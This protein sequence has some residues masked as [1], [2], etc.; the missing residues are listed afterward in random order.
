M[1]LKRRLEKLGWENIHT[2]NYSTFHGNVLQMVEE[3]GKRVEEIRKSTGAS[4]IDIIAHSLGGIVSRTYMNLSEGRG[5]VRK[6]VTLGTPHQGTQLSF[7]A[8]GLSR[9][10]LDKDLRV[11][12]YLLRLLQDTT[13]PKSSE[14]VSVYSPFDWT[15]S[16]GENGIAK[17]VPQAAFK[18]VRVD[19]IGHTGLLYSE[20]A[21]EAI[22]TAIQPE[23][24]RQPNT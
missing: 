16:P 10:A 14:I 21:F 3:L 8:K 11:N 15:V 5:K 20:D 23:S 17:G 7:V 12:S 9:G 2:V 19:Y 18:N 13:L 1:L 22:V 6:L 24:A 4:Q